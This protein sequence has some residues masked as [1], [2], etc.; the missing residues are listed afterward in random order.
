MKKTNVKSKLS[1]IAIIT[2]LAIS[3]MLFALSSVNAQ[4]ANSIFAFPYIN[5]VPN[6]SEVNTV[7]VL[8]VGSVYPTPSQVGG[9]SGLTVEVT[10]PDGSTETLGPINTDTTGGTGVVYTPTLVGTYTLKT[11]FPETVTT[12]SGYYGA[13]GTIME[14]SYSETID[15]VV[16]DEP[17]AY[18]PGFDLPTEYWSRPIDAQ[19]REWYRISNNW[20]GYVPPTNPDPHSII[21]PFNDY[22]PETGHVLWTKPLTMGGLAGGTMYEQGFEQGDA[23]VGKFGGGGLFGAAGPVIIGGILFYNQFES[24]G[25]ANVDQWVNAVDLHTGE[26]LWSKSLTTPDGDVLR[27]VFGQT[28]YW[29]SYNYHGVFDFLWATQSAGWFGPTNWHAFDPITGRWVYSIEGMPSGTKVYG[30]KGEIFLYDL[31]KNAGTLTL[32]NSSRVVSTQGSFDPQGQRYNATRG[33]EWT[34]NIPGL[35]DLPGSAYKYRSGV[36][37][38]SNFQRGSPAPN[39]AS[40][41][42]VSVDIAHGTAAIMWHTEWTLPFDNALITVEDVSEEEDLFIVSTKQARTTYGFRLSTGAQIWGPTPSRFYTDNWGHSSGNSWDIIADGKVIAGNYGGTVW[43]YSAVN[44]SVLWT[45]DIVDPYVETLHGNNWRFRPSFVADGKLYVENTEH[46]PR[47]PQPRGAPFLCLD[48]TTGEKVWELP[49]RGSEWGTSPMIAD[50]IICMYN[51]YDQRIYA[52]GKGPS[53]ITLS[54]P[55]VAIP[56]GTGCA[57]SGTVMDVSPGTESERVTLRFPNG[58]PVSSD[59]GM[60]EWMLYVYNQWP[61]PANAVGVEVRI[62]VVNPNYEYAWIGTVTSDA[63]GNY[64]YSFVPQMKGT[65]TIITT[66]VGSDSYYG[67]QATAYLVADPAPTQVTIPSYP[68]YQGPSAQ[69][70]ANRVLDNLPDSPTA[71]NIATEVLNQLPEYPAATVV[72]EYT[73]IDIV[74]ILLVAVAIAIGVISLLKKQ[75]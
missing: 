67:A 58:V 59:E 71:G 46:N 54:V 68:G 47:D 64:G 9:W 40:M 70:V 1:T 73:T 43:C 66:F 57:I 45:Y 23:Y 19:M 49:Y 30:P 22:A 48:M 3:S 50:S 36:I 10:K 63:Y 74:I 24:N 52:I 12:A 25:G 21:A 51:N 8:H 6:P 11:H 2:V 5:A 7:V 72:P 69:D 4:E 13:A 26:L 65:Y 28:F 39:P 37:L 38:G 16:T 31:N 44:G 33:I 61:R 35:S 42:A 18:Y 34:V 60:S 14:D 15:L 27:L 32:W 55:Q 20:L 75:K 53:A 56:V 29:D 41:W 62:Q 17:V